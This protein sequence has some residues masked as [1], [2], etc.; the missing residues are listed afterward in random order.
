MNT[1]LLYKVTITKGYMMG[2]CGTVY[3]TVPCGKNTKYYEGFDDGGEIYIL[4]D[5]YELCETEYGNLEFYRKCKQTGKYIHVALITDNNTPVLVDTYFPYVAE[6]IRLEKIM[7]A[8]DL[9]KKL[10]EL[11]DFGSYW[12]D[13]DYDRSYTY[14]I[15]E[16]AKI[17]YR[18][19]TTD[20]EESKG[21][22]LCVDDLTDKQL[23]ND[24]EIFN[25]RV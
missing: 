2:E 14:W 5:G 1:V 23:I 4:P 25:K 16:T 7:K 19:D 8:E 24:I 10:R 12:N 20:L 15:D 9:R 21:L 22:N 13:A 3:S 18:Y 17:E 6:F 11:E